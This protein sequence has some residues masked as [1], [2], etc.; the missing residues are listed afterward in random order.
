MTRKRPAPIPPRIG[1]TVMLE[2]ELPAL[3]DKA[4]AALAAVLVQL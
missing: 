3:S 1:Q 2:I 4:A